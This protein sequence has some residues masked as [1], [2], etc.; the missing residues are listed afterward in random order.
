M[1]CTVFIATRLDGYIATPDGGVDWLDHVG[2][3]S[4]DLGE[5]ADMGFVALMESVDCLIMGR[6][7]PFKLVS[8][9]KPLVGMFGLLRFIN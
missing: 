2:D 7:L 4:A 5:D 9:C 6:V 8:S 1:K 3:Q